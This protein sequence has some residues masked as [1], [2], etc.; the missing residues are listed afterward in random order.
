MIGRKI[1]Y[2]RNK[3]DG[4]VEEK[5]GY[6]LSVHTGPKDGPD[7]VSIEDEKGHII[8]ADTPYCQ[9]V[10]PLADDRKF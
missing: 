5:I 8:T 7:Y 4:T 2:I 3:P 1:R 6:F 10:N 9:F